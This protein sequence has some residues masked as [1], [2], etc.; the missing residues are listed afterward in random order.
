[1]EARGWNL[2]ESRKW[3][4]KGQGN[5]KDTNIDVVASSMIQKEKIKVRF[6]RHDNLISDHVGIMVKIK[7]ETFAASVTRTREQRVDK[8]WLR[9]ISQQFL[10]EF[11]QA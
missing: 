4:R 2:H 11:V 3:T 6:L 1:M 9:K 7:D 8:E 10:I 5:Q